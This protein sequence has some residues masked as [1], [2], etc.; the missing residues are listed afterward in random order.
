VSL[1]PVLH[2]SSLLLYYTPPLVL[3]L[4]TCTTPLLL[5]YTPPPSCTTPL[6][7]YYNPPPVLHPSSCTTPFHLCYTPPP[8]LH[9]YISATVP[10]HLHKVGRED[11]APCCR[12]LPPLNECRPT[13]AAPDVEQAP[14]AGAQHHLGTLHHIKLQGGQGTTG[15]RLH[16]HIL[17]L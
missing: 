14:C 12:P 7:L 16:T 3:H 6:L 1:P 5:Y 15:R 11:V 8:V 17:N 4:T 10:S 9:P 2:P 13:A